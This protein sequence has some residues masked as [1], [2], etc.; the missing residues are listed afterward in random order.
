MRT[1]I[2]VTGCHDLDRPKLGTTKFTDIFRFGTSRIKLMFLCR[3]FLTVPGRY[4]LRRR[5]T[6][7]TI[8]AIE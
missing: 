5:M 2:T 1:S 3:T 6:L 7:P 8:F 4:N